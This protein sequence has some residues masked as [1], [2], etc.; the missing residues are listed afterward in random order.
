MKA[1]TLN[2]A[3]VNKYEN[4]A[5]AF[6][7]IEPFHN[8]RCHFPIRRALATGPVNSLV[9]ISWRRPLSLMSR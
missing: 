6:L 8:T 7:A 2:R 9:I 4:K 5:N 3:N 1:R